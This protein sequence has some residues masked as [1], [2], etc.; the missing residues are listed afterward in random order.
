MP[1]EPLRGTATLAARIHQLRAT[2]SPAQAAVG[3]YGS[4]TRDGCAH[5]RGPMSWGDGSSCLGGGQ[6]LRSARWG[7]SPQRPD[8]TS[9]G[10][11][12]S[13]PVGE[14]CLWSVCKGLQPQVAWAPQLV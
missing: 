8:R 5:C 10:D 6:C 7:G 4:L 1:M 2:G 13:Y 14:Q 12:E 3:A 11:G 9:W